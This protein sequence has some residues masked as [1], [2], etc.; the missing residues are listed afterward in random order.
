MAFSN[1]EM[2][3]MAHGNNHK[4]YAYTTADAAATVDTSGY[5][6]NFSDQFDLGDIIFVVTVDSVSVPTSVSGFSVHVVTSNSGGVV[7]VS[8][9]LFGAALS[10][11]D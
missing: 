5:F 3:L 8:D 2:V 10:D 4:M 9:T 1:S 6:D 11:T 7:N